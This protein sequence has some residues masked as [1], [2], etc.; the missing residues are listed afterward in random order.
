MHSTIA[1]DPQSRRRG[2]D[3]RSLAQAETEAR[4]RPR[5]LMAPS[6]P[7]ARS[8]SEGAVGNGPARSTSGAAGPMVSW[9]MRSIV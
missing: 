4:R 8:A 6:S 5:L 2:A 3:V 9:P 7:A 1:V